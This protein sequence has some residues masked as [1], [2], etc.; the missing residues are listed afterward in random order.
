[1][2]RVPVRLRKDVEIIIFELQHGSLDATNSG[3]ELGGETLPQ[4]R[5]PISEEIIRH[6]TL[7]YISAKRD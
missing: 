7:Q 4:R 6:G 3:I 2:V 5:H 1:M